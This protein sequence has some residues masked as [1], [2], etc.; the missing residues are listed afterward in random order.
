MRTYGTL[1][2]EV[3]ARS[4][5][6]RLAALA[7]IERRSSLARRIEIMTIRPRLRMAQALGA[8][9]LAAAFVLL[10]CETPV[11]SQLGDEATELALLDGTYLETAV[12][13]Q[14]QRISSPRLEYPR[15]LK[16]AGIEGDV[17]M[18]AIVGTDG[19]V[20][21]GSVEILESSHEAFDLP[22]KQLL[23]G[24]R[25]RPGIVDGKAVRTV[26]QLPIQFTII[27]KPIDD[28]PDPP[29]GGVGSP[30]AR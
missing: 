22:S 4:W 9:V 5:Y 6:P 20:E 19:R 16:E 23:E 24:S 17:L 28:T 14:P 30:V 2:L 12:D 15:L 27:D 7:L 29:E 3:G 25:F 10:A 26:I 18:Q 11:P 8:V 13:T 21:P 1:L